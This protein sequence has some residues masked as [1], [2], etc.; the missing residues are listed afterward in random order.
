MARSRPAL[1]RKGNVTSLADAR[2]KREQQQQAD[3]SAYQNAKANTLTEQSGELATNGTSDSGVQPSKAGTQAKKAASSEKQTAKK[4]G[5]RTFDAE[6]V[7]RLKAAIAD[8]TYKI[9][10]QRTA[11]KFIERESA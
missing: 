10:A 4:I 5:N 6:K 2:R 8:G 11:D 7:A 3:E 1:I 9:N